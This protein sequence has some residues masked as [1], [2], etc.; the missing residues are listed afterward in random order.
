MVELSGVDQ[1]PLLLQALADAARSGAT[2][3]SLDFVE[4]SIEGRLVEHG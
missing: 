2:V 1:Q 3:Y 4:A